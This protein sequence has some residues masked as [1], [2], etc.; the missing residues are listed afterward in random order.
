MNDIK[1]DLK[2]SSYGFIKADDL[3]SLDYQSNKLKYGKI[4][5]AQMHSFNDIAKNHCGATLITNLCIFFESQ[6]YQGLLID[7][8]IRK[9]FEHI[10]SIIGNGPII[11]TARTAKRY[12]AKKGYEL[13]YKMIY[14]FGQIKDAIDDNMPVSMLLAE[15]IFEWHWVLAVGYLKSDKL[16][17]VRIINAWE[18]TDQRFYLINHKSNFFSAV[19]YSIKRK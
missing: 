5:W 2:T 18:D 19:K 13:S 16:E 14:N 9:T 7:G 4:T 6:G 3:P 12:F 1:L 11:T 17:F 8:S 15:K 10:H